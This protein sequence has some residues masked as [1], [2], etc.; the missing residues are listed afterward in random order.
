MDLKKE[1]EAIFAMIE[2]EVKRTLHDPSEVI[3]R[4]VQPI[5]WIAIFG[6]I[7]A[8]MKAFPSID[9]YVTFITP[10]VILQSAT[11]TA[12]SYGIMLVFER[13][14]GILKRLISSP[15]KRISIVA[16]RAFGGAT[17]AAFQYIVILLVAVPLGAHIV[18]NPIN[19]GIGY[20]ILTITCMGFTSISII[21]ASL[22]KKRER[23]MGILGAITMPLFF[24]SNALYPLDA[25]PAAIR[26]FALV[27]PLTYTVSALRT[28][29]IKGSFAILNEAVILVM[30]S[31]ISI[32]LAA[33][34][35][36]KI[37]E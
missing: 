12:L 27:N 6:S 36:Q 37:I 33:K 7:M 1:I 10:G 23:F 30:F 21:I 31:T 17:R 5:L 29:L 18:L 25:M 13:E 19:L 28:L 35:L 9:D 2:L 8:K 4:A 26:Y 11:M 15:A 3:T 14:S 32:L 20:I 22:L 24:G 34:Y 16:G